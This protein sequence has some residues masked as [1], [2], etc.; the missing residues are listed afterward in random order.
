MLYLGPRG[1]WGREFFSDYRIDGIVDV[2]GERY[3][4]GLVEGISE[5]YNELI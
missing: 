2:C 4:V 3:F 1:I 5:I